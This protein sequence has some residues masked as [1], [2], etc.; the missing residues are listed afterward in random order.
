MKGLSKRIKMVFS[1]FRYL[2]SC[3]GRFR[4]RMRFGMDQNPELQ[5]LHK[6]DMEPRVLP[7]Q[8]QNMYHVVYFLWCNTRAKFQLLYLSSYRDVT[9]FVFLHYTNTPYDVICYL[10]CIIQKREYL[11]NQRRYQKK[12]NTIFFHFE[13]PFK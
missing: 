9:N 7:Q 2:L 1:F 5:F 10:I 4:W 8:H 3:R 6:R 13:K 12:E 11:Y